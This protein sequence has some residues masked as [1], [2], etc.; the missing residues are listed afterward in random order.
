MPRM[1]RAR[2]NWYEPSRSTRLGARQRRA[3]L[4]SGLAAVG[5]WWG[6]AAMA[7]D[8]PAPI[9]ASD[10]S[11]FAAPEEGGLRRWIVATE[12][13]SEIRADAGPVHKI[14]GVVER[15]VVLANFGCSR[16]ASG[17]WCEVAR[18]T[19][20]QRGFVPADDLAPIA[21]P[22]GVVAV[23]VDD[24]PRRARRGDFDAADDIACAQEVGETM[25]TCRAEVARSSGGDATLIANFANGFR[26][27]LHFQHGLFLRGNATMSGVGTD[28]DWHLD[29]GV[30][31]VRVDDQRFEVPAGLI[32]GR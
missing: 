19:G 28:T 23:G 20:G 25:G 32:V 22:D 31:H 29:G 8:A 3:I 17:M 6:A 1:C 18:L 2:T 21:G 13:P 30:Y 24:S 15:G 26:R 14:V 16:L 4:R 12:A 5:L 9:D 7:Q 27:V 11:A 10:R